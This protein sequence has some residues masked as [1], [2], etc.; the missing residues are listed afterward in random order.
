MQASKANWIDWIFL[1]IQFSYNIGNLQSLVGSL[2]FHL[3]WS[4]NNVR[5][6]MNDFG[7]LKLDLQPPFESASSLSTILYMLPIKLNG[8]YFEFNGTIPLR[9][10]SN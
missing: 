7:A 3:Q 8:M 9:D 2:E 1:H 4:I 10:K 6:L 5:T